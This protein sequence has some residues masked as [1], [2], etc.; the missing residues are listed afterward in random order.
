[1]TAILW[2]STVALVIAA[3]YT[4]AKAAALLASLQQT[5]QRVQSL[6]LRADQVLESQ[7][8]PLMEGTERVQEDA[9]LL[10]LRATA[11]AAT[12]AARQ[13]LSPDTA[14]KALLALEVARGI[15]ETIRART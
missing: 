10:K 5:I 8:V 12:A 1:M 4:L 2:L 7:V 14:R 6:R 13:T 15:L 3:W 9:A 11:L